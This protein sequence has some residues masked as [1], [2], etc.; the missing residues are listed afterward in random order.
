MLTTLGVQVTSGAA[1]VALAFVALP[2]SAQA[3]APVDAQARQVLAETH[4]NGLAVG[5][6]DDGHV[7]HVA[8]FGIRNAT[9]DALETSTV[10]YGASL[11]KAVFTYV[12]MRLVDAG[13]LDL[14]RP[15]ASYLAKPLP[16]YET[17]ASLAGDPRWKAITARHALTHSTGFANFAFIEPD[18]K[19]HL[20]FDPGTRYA[21]SGEGLLLLQFVLENGLHIDVAAL[22]KAEFT[23]LGMTRTSL[24]WREDFAANLADAWNDRGEPQAHDERSRV[25]AAGSMDT[26]IADM[27]IF[28]A[29]LVKGD[30]LSPASRAAITKPQLH[31]TTA[32]QFP[33]FLPELPSAQQRKDLYAGLGV[34]VFDGPQG[35]GFYKGGHDEQTANTMVCLEGSRRC[36]VLLSNDV[37]AEAG[38]AGL[39][40][41]VLG[42]TGVPYDWEYG[43]GAGKSDP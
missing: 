17:Y 28:A 33:T 16:D 19:L 23:R 11:T 34:V 6:I 43:D 20:H 25:R 9:R 7:T 26:S 1:V 36:V 4:A 18:Q 3:P 15:L 41:G 24:I 21:Y 12:V 22:T 14:D 5:V 27:A 29:A 8:A 37:R 2:L 35:R 10:M 30:G 32:H 38:F 42:D 39:V 40:R 31:I 13:K